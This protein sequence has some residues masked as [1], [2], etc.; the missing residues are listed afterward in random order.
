MRNEQKD[1]CLKT[2]NMPEENFEAHSTL[3]RRL[4]PI[5]RESAQLHNEASQRGNQA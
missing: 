2:T 5:H 4:N 1:V 3:K